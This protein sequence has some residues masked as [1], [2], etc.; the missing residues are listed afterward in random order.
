MS[1]FA[2]PFPDR[3]LAGKELERDPCYLK[4][5]KEDRAK[6][7]D[8]AWNKGEKAAKSVFER[9]DG[10]PDFFEIMKTSGLTVVKEDR[11]YVVGNHR[12]FCDYL[13]GRKRVRLFTKSVDLWAKKNQLPLD[14]ACNV[15]L[16]HEYFHFLEHT[17]LR[18]TSREYQVPMLILG[19]IK[20]GSTGILALSEIGA[21]A[22]AHTYYDLVNRRESEE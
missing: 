4:I 9:F 15:I 7:I 2:L 17:E 14:T 16:M 8:M 19:S 3:E 22:F 6:V 21:H 20:L 12:F 13:T 11:D 10:S 18:V 5:P 1:D